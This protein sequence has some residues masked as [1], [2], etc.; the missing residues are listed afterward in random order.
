MEEELDTP[1]L[2]TK[3]VEALHVDHSV[4]LKRR[5]S[6][7]TCICTYLTTD[8]NKLGSPTSSP[9]RGVGGLET[10]NCWLALCLAAGKAERQAEFI[11]PA[12]P[13]PAPPACLP[14]IPASPPWIKLSRE[15]ETRACSTEKV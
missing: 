6:L 4:R 1:R 14:I 15:Q 10:N 2:Q 7:P 5:Y 9:E 3:Q 11:R 12:P 8:V 13:R